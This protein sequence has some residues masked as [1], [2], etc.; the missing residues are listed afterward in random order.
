MFKYILLLLL[1][2]GS[3]IY[4]QVNPKINWLSPSAGPADHESYCYT[5]KGDLFLPIGMVYYSIA[6]IPVKPGKP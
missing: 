1:L 3:Q 4:S 2:T 5:E 6:L